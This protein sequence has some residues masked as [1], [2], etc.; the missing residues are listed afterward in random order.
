LRGRVVEARRRITEWHTWD[1]PQGEMAQHAHE[2]LGEDLY[3][4]LVQAEYEFLGGDECKDE[5]EDL[6][7]RQAQI[8]ASN[9]AL[10]S[11]ILVDRLTREP[12]HPFLFTEKDPEDE[13]GPA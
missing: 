9:F 8:R 2:M 10:K 1:K 5:E 11:V 6:T 13:P 3:D 7:W 12:E 4:E